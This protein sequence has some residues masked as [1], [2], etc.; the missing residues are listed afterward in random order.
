MRSFL[1][2][3]VLTLSCGASLAQDITVAAAA[4]LQYAF[5]DVATRFEKTDGHHV[6]LIFGSSGNFFAQIQNG[7]P[8]DLFFSADSDYPKKLETSGLAEPGTFYAYATGKIVLWAPKESKLDLTQGLSVLKDPMAKKIA[9]ANPEHAPYGR[10][11]VAALHHENLYDAVS[12]KFVL[13]ENIAQTAEFV[14][15]GNA[16]VGIIALS[17]ALSPAMQS[18][19]RYVEIPAEDY[20][21]IQQAAVILKSSGQKN[22]SRQFLDFLK[23]PPIV[24][25]L[26]GY[27][28]ANPASH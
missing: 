12:G 3:L 17:L 9:I 10:A 25:L 14:A 11:A 22:I 6:K 21:A 8:F 23:T 1:I 26:H 15:T 18:K 20:P 7:A 2:A 19:G 4:D 27:G 5:Q 13:G 16:D 24:D 28:F